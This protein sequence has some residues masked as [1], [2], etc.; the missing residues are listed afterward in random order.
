MSKKTTK[1]KAA[2]ERDALKSLLAGKAT[3]PD[4]PGRNQA[5]TALEETPKPEVKAPEP[6]PV[7]VAPVPVE[8]PEPEEPKP[9][10]VAEVAEAAPE[11][12]VKTKK[13][14]TKK[15]GGGLAKNTSISLHPADEDRLDA[16]EAALR[17]KRVVGRNT[18]TSFLVK[19][20]LAAVDLSGVDLEAAV[21]A[22][23]E[24]DNRY[25]AEEAA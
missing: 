8:T 22:V 18:P 9:A 19:V 6:E 15:G 11:P 1:K 21:D 12:K 2:S 17:K 24:Q 14:K 25:K 5:K 7:G 10:P 4:A 23:R 3:A 20:A 16:I 13:A